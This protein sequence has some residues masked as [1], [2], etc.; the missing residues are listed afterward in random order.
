LLRL[1][2]INR[3]RPSTFTML[4]SFL[5]CTHSHSVDLMNWKISN[6]VQLNKVG[7]S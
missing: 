2:W 6:V 5:S 3:F 1:S 4:H 7:I